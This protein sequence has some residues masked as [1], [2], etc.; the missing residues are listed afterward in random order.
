MSPNAGGGGRGVSAKDYSCAHGAQKTFEDLT[1]YLT[2]VLYTRCVYTKLGTNISALFRAILEF[3]SVLLI[4]SYPVCEDNLWLSTYCTNCV[5]C[6]C[7]VMAIRSEHG[8]ELHLFNILLHWNYRGKVVF[9]ARIFK[10]SRSPRIDSEEPIPPGCV[11]WR[12]GTKTLFLLG[13]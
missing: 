6:T 3:V 2:C 8:I 9:W 12:A 5:V 13:S 7:T 1:P 10:L 4:K 11:A